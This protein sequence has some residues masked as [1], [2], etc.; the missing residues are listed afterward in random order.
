MNCFSGTNP[1]NKNLSERE[2][3]EHMIAHHQVAIE[4]SYRM[5]KFTQDQTVMLLCRNIIWSQKNQIMGMK[6][7]WDFPF[8]YITGNYSSKGKKDRP[9]CLQEYPFSYYYP[10][11]SQI[12]NADCSIM[13]FD[14]EHS[15]QSEH[16]EHQKNV[17]SKCD[18]KK[19]YMKIWIKLLDPIASACSNNNQPITDKEF[20]KH[21]VEHH[22]IAI[23]MSKN[24][25]NVTQNTTLTALAN[26][27]IRNQQYEIW[28]MNNLLHHGFYKYQ[29]PNLDSSNYPCDSCFE[30][31]NK[32]FSVSAMR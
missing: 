21:M 11:T 16:S 31:P 22:Q 27:I 4:M 15:E 1:C 7:L 14:P 18:I 5:L 2:F 24:L 9:T 17:F 6:M 25:L 28:F 32:C 12:P 29:S 26:E 30:N 10:C 8:A 13:F 19:R 3:L 23:D 20:M